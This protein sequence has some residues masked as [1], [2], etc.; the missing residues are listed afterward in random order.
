MY[1]ID[2]SVLRKS[3]ADQRQKLDEQERALNVLEEM[4][5]LPTPIQTRTRGILNDA[6][7]KLSSGTAT[8][9]AV[10]GGIL[11]RAFSERKRSLAEE[12]LDIIKDFRGIEFT[13]PDVEN[14]LNKR[15]V[16]IKGK[17]P[18][19]QIAVNM[20]TLEKRGKVIRTERSLGNNPHKFR[21]AEESKLDIFS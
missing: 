17:S 15:R 9:T 5:A 18:R 10:T 16:I 19:A 4:L 12:I 8:A 21:L 6:A 1:Q 20:G 2:I 14:E 11:N 7:N 3:I 13:V